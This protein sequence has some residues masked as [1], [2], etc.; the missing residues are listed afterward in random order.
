MTNKPALRKN[1]GRK[2]ASS[3]N[4]NRK[5]ASGKNNGNGKVDEFGVDSVKYI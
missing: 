1:N 2:S 5:P 4:N 3:R